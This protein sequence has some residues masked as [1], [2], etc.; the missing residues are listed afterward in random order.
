VLHVLWSLEIGGA[1]RAVY[2]LV[3]EQR[4]RG[5]EADVAVASAPGLYGTSLQE[6]GVTVHELRCRS[7]ADV[8]RSVRLATIAR[9]YSL[10]HVHAI[11]PLLMAA[12]ARAET[13]TV[14]THRGGIRNHGLVKRSRLAFA[15]P[16]VRGFEALSGNTRQSARVL[17]DWLGLASSEV[18]VTYN[19]IDFDLLRPIRERGDVLSEL[20]DAARSSILVGTASKF[21]PLKRVELLIEAIARVPP[22]LQCV[23]IG[24]GPSRLPLERHAAHLGVS[25][26]VTFVGRKEHVGDYLQLLD[27]FVLPSGPEEAFGNAA[28]EA[29]GVGVP[30]VV[31]ADG[32]GLT[33]HVTNGETGRVVRDVRELAG[34]LEELAADAALRAR[35]GRAGQE[36][37]RTAYS[38]EAM[39]DGYAVLYERALGIAP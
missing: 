20:P 33:E 13:V 21:Q 26:R 39:F 25:D 9:A 35:L 30:T 23:V 16:F 37:V 36:Y 32:G 27:V 18:A 2:Q 28:V 1:E 14:Y 3:L 5:I 22:T 8:L 29:M 38:L 24:D 19:G 10:V 7:A 11:E 34:T 17:A 12:A 15:R 31:F 4:R 6:R